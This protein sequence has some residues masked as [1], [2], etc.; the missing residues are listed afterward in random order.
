[1]G[2]GRPHVSNRRQVPGYFVHPASTRQNPAPS[3]PRPTCT[4][5]QR[6]TR[7]QRPTAPSTMTQSEQAVMSA[8]CSGAS[9]YTTASWQSRIC[10]R[11]GVRRSGVE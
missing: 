5:S 1:M 7:R 9:A 8:Y 6:S 10:G 11:V 2:W 3:L 4:R